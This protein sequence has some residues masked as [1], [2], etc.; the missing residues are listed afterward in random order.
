LDEEIDM[1]FSKNVLNVK[2]VLNV[3]SSGSAKAA[4]LQSVATELSKYS[5]LS[6]LFR[7]AGI[8]IKEH[9]EPPVPS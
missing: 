7:P 1:P 2:Y 5:P 4:G 6:K 8:G 3:K 9:C